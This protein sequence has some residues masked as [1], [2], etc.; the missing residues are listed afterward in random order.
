[1]ANKTHKVAG[2]FATLQDTQ[3]AKNLLI[4]RGI[5][6]AHINL[7]VPEDKMIDKK[8][9]PDGDGVAKE[10]VKD[11]IIGGV[12]GGG[13]GAAGAAAMAAASITLFVA[14]PVL[15]PLSLMGWGAMIGIIAG[16]GKGAGI[17]EDQFADMVKDVTNDGKFI[18]M[19]HTASENE[20]KVAH[21]TLAELTQEKSDVKSV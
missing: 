11:A 18:L 5:T 14:S 2:I 4:E 6:P 21:D 15:G 19:V 9:E 13:V 1:M 17:R 7:I 10:V 12:I 20:F 8:I 3:S 16:G